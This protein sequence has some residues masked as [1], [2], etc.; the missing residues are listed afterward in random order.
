MR[1]GR[2][3]QAI[4]VL[5]HGE[6][7]ARMLLLQPRQRMMGGVRLGIAKPP[8]AE[9]V[10]V[11]HAGRIAGKAFR[12]RHLF[13]IELRPQPAFVA[14]RAEPALG[15]KPRA[16]EDDDAAENHQPLPVW[17]RCRR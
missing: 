6:D 3:M 10:E 15:G 13:E 11:V 1:A 5:R 9:I 4:D 8:P 14:E 12:R 17:P 7:A 2:L 16:G